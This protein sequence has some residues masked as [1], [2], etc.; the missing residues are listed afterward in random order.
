MFSG[1]I[2]HLPAVA[3]ALWRGE[4]AD[5]TATKVEVATE[6]VADWWQCRRLHSSSSGVMAAVASAE[7]AAE[8]ATEAAT[9]A[10]AATAVA[11]AQAAAATKAAATTKGAGA[12]KGVGATEGAVATA[13]ACQLAV[14]GMVGSLRRVQLMF[15]LPNSFPM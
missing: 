1:R 5:R 11:A 15:F 4:A 7:A 12:T 9:E 3:L 10:A 13:V 2:F 14:T 8:A 6:A